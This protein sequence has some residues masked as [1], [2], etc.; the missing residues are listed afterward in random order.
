MSSL[1]KM[2]A[3]ADLEE[4]H[5]G[6][7]GS[8][9]QRPSIIT[10]EKGRHTLVSGAHSSPNGSFT[11]RNDNLHPLPAAFQHQKR[12][13]APVGSGE[14]LIELHPL[15][16]IY[17]TR[18][19][20][21]SAAFSGAREGARVFS[22]PM[23]GSRISPKS[24]PPLDLSRNPECSKALAPYGLFEV[25]DGS[26]SCSGSSNNSSCP[27]SNLRR[28]LQSQLEVGKPSSTEPGHAPRHLTLVYHT[29]LGEAK[30]PRHA[31][32]CTVVRPLHH[33]PSL[34]HIPDPD[35][36][37]SRKVIAPPNRNQTSHPG[38]SH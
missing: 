29:E 38:T 3:S 24:P 22:A 13:G 14:G 28:P 23:L 20:H 34:L 35:F 1:C 27:V 10:S 36:R 37:A 25:R 9:S 21:K 8:Q 11:T 26:G 6:S 5:P 32:P 7:S 16:E 17:S 19:V 33:P 4:N 12:A 18:Q 30:G 2:F 31:I 15:S